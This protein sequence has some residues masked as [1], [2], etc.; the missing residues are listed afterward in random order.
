MPAK[1]NA[2]E[3]NTT[4]SSH[5]SEFL[6]AA[7]EVRSK[8]AHP[9]VHLT[10][11]III[12]LFSA[13]ILWAFWG[14][15]DI[16]AKAEGKIIPTGQVRP[17]Q[18]VESGVVMRLAVSEG[19]RVEQGELLIQLTPELIDA[20]LERGR[21]EIRSREQLL[22]RKDQLLDL[23][24]LNEHGELIPLVNEPLLLQ[25]F[26]AYQSHIQQRQRQIAERQAAK[27]RS[28]QTIEKLNALEPVVLERLNA[29]KRLNAKGHV[30]RLDYLAQQ[31]T[32]IQLIHERLAAINE[33]QQLSADIAARSSELETFK[34]EYRA[35]ALA[36]IEQY[37]NEIAAQQQSLSQLLQR[38]ANLA[39]RAPISGR[40]QDLNV[41]SA[42]AVLANAEQVMSIVPVDAPLEVEAWLENRDIGFVHPGNSSEIKLETFP[43]TKYGVLH[44][45]VVDLS[46]DATQTDT[47]L[48]YKARIALQSRE[49]EIDNRVVALMPGMG[50]T[51][52]IRTG[53]RRVIDY[54]FDP[55]LRY[56]NESLRER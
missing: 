30:A 23:I 19:Q 39:V 29:L 18:T 45:E 22:K 37:G 50:V 5:L 48:I 8:A 36:E 40:V 49:I 54:I 6:P 33:Q 16:V 15:I 21:I 47:G 25:E 56:R 12:A 11:G 1:F 14:E 3:S 9:A 28:A 2:R 32:H 31:E 43:F 41:R 10:P 24:N 55:L 34:L 27:E 4:Q 13:L 46:A 26:G 38:R 44:G 35:N 52:E 7:L 17:V 20:E 51:A 53:R 42:G